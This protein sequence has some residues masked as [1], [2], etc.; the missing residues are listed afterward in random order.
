MKSMKSKVLTAIQSHF[1]MF[2]RAISAVELKD[3][4][5]TE[6]GFEWSPQRFQDAIDQLLQEKKIE[7]SGAKMYKL[8]GVIVNE[9]PLPTAGEITPHP[10]RYV[11]AK[12]VSESLEE[13]NNANKQDI[14]GVK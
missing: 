4:V 9:D 5:Q 6:T 10:A 1:K 11:R 14:G 7:L 3:S 13:C 12:D 8:Y 2:S